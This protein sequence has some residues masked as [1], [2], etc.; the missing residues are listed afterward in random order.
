MIIIDI[1]EFGKDSLLGPVIISQD[2]HQI[3]DLEGYTDE[4]VAVVVGGVTR[5]VCRIGSDAS[6]LYHTI[7]RGFDG[8]LIDEEFCITEERLDD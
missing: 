5:Y 1:D 2:G 7:G 3:A 4:Y 6:T 8:R